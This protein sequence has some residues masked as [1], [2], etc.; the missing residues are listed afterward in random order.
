MQSELTRVINSLK[1][2]VSSKPRPK[3]LNFILNYEQFIEVLERIDGRIGW[4]DLKSEIGLKIESMIVNNRLHG[5]PTQREELHTLITGDPGTGKTTFGSD[6]AELWAVSGCLK[7]PNPSP[8]EEPKQLT[9]S[10]E[11]TTLRQQLMVKE[12]QMKT[13]REVHQQS[14]IDAANAVNKINRLWKKVPHCKPELGELKKILQGVSS[15]GG[16]SPIRLVINSNIKLLPVT[17]PMVPYHPVE[18]GSVPLPSLTMGI[19]SQSVKTEPSAVTDGSSKVKFKFGI[20]VRGDFLGKYQGHTS[21]R[22][23]TLFKDYE[24]GVVMIDEAYDLVTSESDDFGRE[25]LTEIINY[26][27]RFPD[28]IIFIFAGYKKSMETI[29]TV[30]PGLQ[31]RFNWKFNIDGYKPEELFSIFTKQLANHHLKIESN[32]ESA[33]R[34]LLNE[35]IREGHFRY[36][37]GDTARLAAYVRDSVHRD[38]FSSALDSD[39]TDE[40]FALLFDDVSL[41]MIQISIERYIRNY[42]GDTKD[43]RYLDYYT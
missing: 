41:E 37:G 31:R 5:T 9:V 4:V 33:I 21:D 30:Q 11:I 16:L 17:I 34:E 38:L 12:S 3:S 42:S 2:F 29:M 15:A 10:P 28:K 39:I 6:L 43:K 25:V 36:Y 7:Q 8:K 24:G 35:Q 13:L 18:F 14:R 1:Q 26:M 32:D 27:S 20:F 23:R 19:D 40:E 22:V